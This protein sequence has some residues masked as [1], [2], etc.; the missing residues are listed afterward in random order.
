MCDVL[1]VMWD[2]VMYRLKSGKPDIDVFNYIR[3]E[4]VRSFRDWQLMIKDG[5]GGTQTVE[6]SKRDGFWFGRHLLFHFGGGQWFFDTDPGE[7]LLKKAK[8]WWSLRGKGNMGISSVPAS[9]MG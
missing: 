6:E 2:L 1:G 4:A 3:G 9:F 5:R 7:K 8:L